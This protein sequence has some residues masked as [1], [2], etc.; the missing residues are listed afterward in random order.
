M[1]IFLKVCSVFIE[2]NVVHHC[3]KQRIS[4]E[5]CNILFPGGKR[6]GYV[7]SFYCQVQQ[8]LAICFLTDFL[9]NKHLYRYNK[10]SKRKR[11]CRSYQSCYQKQYIECLE[12]LSLK[13]GTGDRTHVSVVILEMKSNT[14]TTRPPRYLS[15]EMHSIF[16]F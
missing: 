12:T 1:Q 3:H 8:V 11:N 14:P 16:H 15:D 5:E 7:I 9:N 13:M 6:T 10:L 4:Q 2:M